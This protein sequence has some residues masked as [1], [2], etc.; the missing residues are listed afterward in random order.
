M[1]THASHAVP[2]RGPGHPPNAFALEQAV[3]EVAAR[4]GVD[5][6]L[7]RLHQA[8]N[9]RHAAVYRLARVRVP[10]VKNALIRGFCKLYPIDLT[11]AEGGTAEDYADFNTFFTRALKAGRRPLPAAGDAIASPCPVPPNYRDSGVELRALARAACPW[12]SIRS[13]VSHPTH[14]SVTETP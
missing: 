10:G 8:R 14:A 11:E 6:L 1:L 13:V 7:L 5:P 12:R 3:D 9:P 2:F 4:M